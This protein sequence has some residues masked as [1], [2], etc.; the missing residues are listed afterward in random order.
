MCR[1]GMRARGVA[2]VDHSPAE[3]EHIIIS[4]N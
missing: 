1:D 4:F 2:R 3:I